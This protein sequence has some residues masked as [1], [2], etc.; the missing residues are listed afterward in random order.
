MNNHVLDKKMKRRTKIFSLLSFLSI[1]SIVL[2]QFQIT[3]PET[4]TRDVDMR[5][6][7]LTLNPTQYPRMYVEYLLFSKVPLI[8]RRD[9]TIV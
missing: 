5:L 3:Q 8:L 6:V 9:D 4:L 7:I 2:T 1:S